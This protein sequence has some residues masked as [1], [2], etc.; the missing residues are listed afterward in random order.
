LE[1]DGAKLQWEKIE[2]LP[3]DSVRLSVFISINA[4]DFFASFI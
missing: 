4:F 1:D 3:E 2:K